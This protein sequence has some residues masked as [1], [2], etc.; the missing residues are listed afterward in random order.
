MGE[1]LDKT[2]ECYTS[3]S[4]ELA[5]EVEPL[6]EVVDLLRDELKSRHIERF[7]TGACTIE[8]GTQF[9]ELLINLERVSDHCS[10]VALQILRRTAPKNDLVLTDTH[11]YLHQLH[12]GSSRSFDELFSAYRAKYLAPIDADK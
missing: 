2:L 9:L 12:H 11:A 7:K 1:A 4:R 5:F 10:N 6:E 8:Q 3:R